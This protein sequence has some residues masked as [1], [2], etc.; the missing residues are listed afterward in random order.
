MNII[1]NILIKFLLFKKNSITNFGIIIT[2]IKNLRLLVKIALSK[3]KT[4]FIYF[5]TFAFKAKK[6]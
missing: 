5:F 3:K 4:N 2:Y 6:S 1:H